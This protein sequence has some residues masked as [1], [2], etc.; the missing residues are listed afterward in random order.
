MKW[1]LLLVTSL[2]LSLW[3]SSS[4]AEELNFQEKILEA[5]SDQFRIHQEILLTLESPDVAV[6][7]EFQ[8]RDPDR[9]FLS[10]PQTKIELKLLDW[11]PTLAQK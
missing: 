7:F 1:I 4:F 2:G 10:E 11:Q 9:A 8:S 6:D 3:G 5:Q